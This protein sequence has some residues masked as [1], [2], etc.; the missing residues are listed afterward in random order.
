[1]VTLPN[2][3]YLQINEQPVFLLGQAEAD[4]FVYSL[5]CNLE[6]G[7]VRVIRGWKCSHYEALHNEV[8]AA[9]QFPDYYGENWDAMDECITDLAWVPA[10]CYLIYLPKVEE[11]L[12]NDEKGFGIFLSVLSDAAKAWANPEMRG[13]AST[14]EPVKKPFNIIISG[15][16]EGLL[17]TKKVLGHAIGNEVK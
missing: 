6:G 2:K 11:V 12:P 4:R 16:E 10:D 17:R 13:L 1:M 14:E 3:F 15:T 8:G 9:L 5:Q 7:S